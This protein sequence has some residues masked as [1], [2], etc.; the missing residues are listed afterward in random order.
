[1]SDVATQTPDRPRP[2]R[3]NYSSEQARA[4]ARARWATSEK[5]R[6]DIAIQKLVDR[7]PALTPEQIAKLRGLFSA[8]ESGTE[9]NGS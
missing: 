8:P 4:A 1:M 7:A 2:R 3:R 6:T 5:Q 9:A